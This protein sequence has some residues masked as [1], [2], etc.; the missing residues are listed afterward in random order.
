MTESDSVMNSSR[1]RDARLFPADEK[2]D[3]AKRIH[4]FAHLK[5]AE[6]GGNLAPRVYFHDDTNGRTGK[7]HVGFVGPHYL[8]PNKSTN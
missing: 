4:M 2:V 5:I 3:E 1:L 8:V 6:G 7:M